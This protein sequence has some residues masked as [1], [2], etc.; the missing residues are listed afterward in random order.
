[1]RMLIRRQPAQEPAWDA[2]PRGA[3]VP[4]LPGIGADRGVGDVALS[5]L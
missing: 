5:K 1:M 2:S 3:I 4:L